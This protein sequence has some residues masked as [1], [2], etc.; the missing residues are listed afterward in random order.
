MMWDPVKVDFGIGFLGSVIVFLGYFV[1]IWH[2]FIYIVFA[3]IKV[4]GFGSDHI[5]MAKPVTS[6]FFHRF[7][8]P[9]TILTLLYNFLSCLTACADLKHSLN[10]QNFHITSNTSLFI[11]L[12]VPAL[13]FSFFTIWFYTFKLILGFIL[14]PRNQ[15]STISLFP[16]FYP[17]I[18]YTSFFLSPLNGKDQNVHWFVLNLSS[19]HKLF[20]FSCSSFTLP[21]FMQFELFLTKIYFIIL[22]CIRY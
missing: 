19:H 4:T 5:H 14:F 6:I 10:N 9:V 8:I 12:S 18:L 21:S 15:Q 16:F 2:I 7:S 11:L 20:C 3:I 13:I 1:V 22:L 17:N